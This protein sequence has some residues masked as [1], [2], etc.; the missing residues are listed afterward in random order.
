MRGSNTVE[1][2]DGAEN[3]EGEEGEDFYAGEPE[4]GLPV[5]GD[6]DDVDEDDDYPHGDRAVV[7]SHT[8]YSW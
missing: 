2:E 5:V 4:F 1:E 8:V 6:G 7:E 3:D